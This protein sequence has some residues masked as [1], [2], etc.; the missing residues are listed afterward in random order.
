[1]RRTKEEAEKTRSAI[2]LAAEVLFL[3]KG[4]GHTTLEQIAKTADVTRGAVYW[5]FQNKAHLFHEMLN[6]VRL[7]PEQMAELLS[8]DNHRE[9]QTLRDICVD[10]LI[11]LVHDEQR[12]RIMTILLFRC[13][14]TDDLREAEDRHNAF[15]RQFIDLCEALFQRA[16]GQGQLHPAMTPRLAAL[17]LHGL[18]IGLFSDYLRDPQLYDPERDAGAM[19]DA[20]FRGLAREW[21]LKD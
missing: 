16:A 8:A 19:V 9:L 1:M 14:F 10:A 21:P 5:H 15:V 13:E 3:Q 12:R 6:Q 11:N 7:P 4:V 17:T 18:V 2:L 20:I